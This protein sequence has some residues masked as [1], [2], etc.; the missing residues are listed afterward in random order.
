MP[1]TLGTVTKTLIQHLEA[2]KLHLEFEASGVIH[3]GSHVG[4]DA[5]GSVSESADSAAFDVVIGFSIHDA[6]DTELVTIA[7]RAYA[8]V[9]GEAEAAS[10]DA[11]PV[12]LGPYNGTTNFREY[13]ASSTPGN[14]VGFNLDQVTDDGDEILVALL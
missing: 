14:T 2:H 4:L 13:L 11:G 12:E 10:L 6:L 5:D 8:L 9:K 1:A 3:A 7:M